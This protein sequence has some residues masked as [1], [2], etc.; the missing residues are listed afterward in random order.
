[1]PSKITPLNL[2]S[3]VELKRH[4]KLTISKRMLKKVGLKAGSSVDVLRTGNALIVV[5]EQKR[6][7][8][9]QKRAR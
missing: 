8:R 4:G 7:K 3:I 6:P 2:L 9:S 1:M 5:P